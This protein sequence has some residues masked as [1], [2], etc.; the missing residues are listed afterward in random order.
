MTETLKDIVYYEWSRM[1]L[2][3]K[4]DHLADKIGNLTNHIIELSKEVDRFKSDLENEE[5]K[6]V[7]KGYGAGGEVPIHGRAGG[8]V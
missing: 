2:E 1:G 6:T 8:E 7:S 3:E 5:N 4:L